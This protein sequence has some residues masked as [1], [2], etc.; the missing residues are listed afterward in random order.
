MQAYHMSP[1]MMEEQ[2]YIALVRADRVREEV[3]EDDAGYGEGAYDTQIISGTSQ[4]LKKEF[5]PTTDYIFR[6]RL[7]AYMNEKNVADNKTVYLGANVSKKAF[8]KIMCGDTVNPSK[9]TVMGFC[10]SLKLDPEEADDLMASAGWAF[11]PYDRREKMVVAL[12]KAG[13]DIFSTNIALHAA[14]LP[15]I[16]NYPED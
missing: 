13:K 6:D 1:A 10:I 5:V 8:S 9:D 14:K 15:C 16:G 3:Y 11:N 2:R 12:L 4:S 7:I